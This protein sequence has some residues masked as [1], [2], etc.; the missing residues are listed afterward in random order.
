MD[1]LKT[2]FSAKGFYLIDP[3]Q[4]KTS[5]W[6]DPAIRRDSYRRSDYSFIGNYFG[7]QV[8]LTGRVRFFK[9]LKMINKNVIEFRLVAH[10]TGTSRIVG[11]VIRVFPTEAGAFETV[12]SQGLKV[13]VEEVSKELADQVFAAWKEGVLDSNRVRFTLLGKLSF[14]SL[15]KIKKEM[16]LRL[17]EVK[18]VKER[19]FEDGK[20]VLEVESGLESKALGA[21]IS[22]MTLPGVKFSNVEVSTNEVRARVQQ[23]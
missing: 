21:K 1:S 9:D 11:E 15:E 17:K 4:W 8:I 3:V 20:V 13:S 10:H 14:D 22:G 5:E 23:Q 7:A 19:L 12:V 2:G 16:P 18:S 6:F